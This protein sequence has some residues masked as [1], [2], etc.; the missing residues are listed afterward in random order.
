M[1]LAALGLVAVLATPAL[2]QP[3]EPPPEAPEDQD[4]VIEPADTL[5]A[6]NVSYN[7]V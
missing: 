3:L 4:Y 7:F 6:G 2:A 5:L 1:R